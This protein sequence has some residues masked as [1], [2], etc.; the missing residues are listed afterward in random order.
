MRLQHYLTEGY[1]P[2]SEYDIDSLIQK[3]CKPYLRQIKDKYLYRGMKISDEAI[4]GQPRMD[5]M[6]KDTAL[7]MSKFIDEVCQKLFGWKPRSQGL[8]AT[9]GSYQA[10]V[11]GQVYE[12][13]PIGNFKFLWSP[14][15]HDLYT[16]IRVLINSYRHKQGKPRTEAYDDLMKIPDFLDVVRKFI[17]TEYR[18]KDLYKAAMHEGEVMILCKSYYGKRYDVTRSL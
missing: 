11:Y 12:I 14:N 4:K 6:P 7:H 13:Y 2:I 1:K 5:R 9:G 17:K 15:V 10:G 16:E 18:D 3:D 8:F